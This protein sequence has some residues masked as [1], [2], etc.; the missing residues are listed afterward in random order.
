MR[1]SLPIFKYRTQLLQLIRDNRVIIMVGE[2]GSGK[3]TQLPQYLNEIGY[4]KGGKVGCTQP[5]RVAAMSVA[6][7]VASEM[8]VKLGH[9]VGYSIRFEECSSEK[10][11]IKYMTDGMLLKE[12]MMDPTLSSYKVIIVDEA[13]E[14][15]LH[16]DVILSLIKDLSRARDDLKVIISSATLDAKKFSDYF[17]QAPIILIPGRRFQVD[18]FYTKA[19]ESDYVE[20]AVVTVLQ[21]HVT[22]EAGDILVFL[23]GQEEIE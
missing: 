21:I 16:T 5:R 6:A 8:G 14:R 12:F 20:A 10:T 4:T 22:Q 7:R 13:H 1:E 17:D 2:T 19:P 11:V 23:T 9:E 18:I 3:T 15:T